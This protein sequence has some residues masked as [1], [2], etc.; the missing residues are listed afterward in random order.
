MH[1][2]DAHTHFFSRA[3]YEFQARQVPGADVQALLDKMAR[4]G[5]ELPPEDHAAHRDRVIADLDHHGV[6]RAITFASVPSEVEIVGEAARGSDGR[7]IPYAVVNP[8]DPAS[9]EAV[10]SAQTLYRFKGVVLFPA[11]HDYDIGAD[12]V[13]PVLALAKENKM[14]VFVHC[15]LLRINI[16]AIL[17]LNPD[18]PLTRAHPE[19]LV[20]VAKAN[21]SLKFIV[22][23]FGAGFF[24]EFL[25]L[26]TACPNVYADTAGSNTWGMFQFPALYLE[27]L[28]EQT[29]DVFGVER[30]LYGSDTAGY[31]RGYR[32]DVLDAQA[33]AMLD[34]GVKPSDQELI[35]GGNLS[36]LLEM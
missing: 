15:G 2:F 22:P 31:P 32:R 13:N 1:I 19:D 34:A 12:I 21:P 5:V 18:F 9:I 11:M 17:G 30:I 3:F 4:H 29:V 24:D 10:R 16:R 23:H 20:P 6:N 28:F 25:R 8:M 14:V 7:L 33:R 27:D 36:E 26:G 35:F